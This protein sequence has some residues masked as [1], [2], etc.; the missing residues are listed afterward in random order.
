M[1]SL[2]ATFVLAAEQVSEK[3]DLYPKLSELILGAVAFAIVF[4]FMAKWVI[5]RINQTL[6]ARRDKIQGDLEKAEQTRQEAEKELTDYRQQLAGAREEANRVIEEARQTAESMRKDLTAKAQEE[7]DQILARAQEEIRAERD[8]VFQEL[9]AQVG[10]LSLALVGRV[11]GDS[12]DQG[13][14]RKLVDRY[15]EELAAVPAAGNGHGSSKG[16]GS[17]GSSGGAS[18]AGE[19]EA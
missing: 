18:G 6:E 14:Q 9:K 3:K 8:R 7:Y 11:I 4:V 19:A 5:P 16:A 12:M 17:S 15:I 10:E 2:V 13:R 1:H